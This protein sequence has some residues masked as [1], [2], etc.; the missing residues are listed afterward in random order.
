MTPDV[1]IAEL[2][3]E[4]ERLTKLVEE[5][6]CDVYCPTCGGCGCEGCCSP[7]NCQLVK[8]KYPHNVETWEE[9]MREIAELTA[10]NARLAEELAGVREE[11]SSLKSL[12]GEAK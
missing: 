6:Q 3:A 10:A 9:N 1:I 7:N 11:L 5:L 12:T 4:V 2:E 8:C